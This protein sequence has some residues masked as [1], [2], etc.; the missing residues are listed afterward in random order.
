MRALPVVLISQKLTRHVVVLILPV[1]AALAGC[2]GSS[3]STTTTATT[4]Q[5][6]T[7]T[8]TPATSAVTVGQNQAFTATVKNSAG[9]ILSGGQLTW[10]SGSTSVATIDSAG[11]ATGVAPGTA[12][13]TVTSE[14]VTSTPVT[15]T[16]TPKV[17]S[18]TISPMSTTVK[19]GS[20]VTFTAK[21]FDAS[22]NQIPSAVFQWSCSAS[23]IATID[24]N[25]NVTGVS[26][27][28]VSITASSGG[29]SS[30]LAMLTVQ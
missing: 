24:S 28:T 22:G 10:S 21:A 14:G 1:V 30:P 8:V 12:S 13:I 23:S 6:A 9:T 15:L 25:G 19:V 7:I 16:V 27:G 3:S 5:I 17:A 26:P 20:T 11:I 2:G 29:I 4:T 18:V